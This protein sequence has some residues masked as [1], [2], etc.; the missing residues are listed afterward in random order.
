MEQLTIQ[1]LGSLLGFQEDIKIIIIVVVVVILA[2][3][4]ARCEPGQTSGSCRIIIISSSSS[5]RSSGGGSS[6]SSSS[7]GSSSSSASSSGS[8]SSSS[9]SSSI[10]LLLLILF[11]VAIDIFPSLCTNYSPPCIWDGHGAI[12]LVGW[13]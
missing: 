10:L 7:S 12:L 9:S 4:D 2:C 11:I 3:L 6:S 13:K 8:S 5:R 1:S